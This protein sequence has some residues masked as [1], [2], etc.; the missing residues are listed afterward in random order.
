MTTFAG[1]APKYTYVSTVSVYAE[2][3]GDLIGETDPC[4]AGDA[5][6]PEAPT[7]AKHRSRSAQVNWQRSCAP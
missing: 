2:S 1:W 3:S 7:M 5:D 6:D 4:V